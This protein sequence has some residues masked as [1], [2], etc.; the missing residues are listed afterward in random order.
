LRCQPTNSS[1]PTANDSAVA[2]GEPHHLGVAHVR[3]LRHS[4]LRPSEKAGYLCTAAT[5]LPRLPQGRDDRYRA[6]SICET[7]RPR[8]DIAVAWKTDE[9]LRAPVEG[10]GLDSSPNS[11]SS[12][13]PLSR[14]R[15]PPSPGARF[16]RRQVAGPGCLLV[17][18]E[19][20]FSRTVAFEDIPCQ[21]K[22]G[23]SQS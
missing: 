19:K 15:Q 21:P 22:A 9:F 10:R 12:P 1:F 13:V 7:S 20:I 6:S 11:P 8:V 2:P 4:S 3:S 16:D 5:C 17:N 23:T 14:H 18:E